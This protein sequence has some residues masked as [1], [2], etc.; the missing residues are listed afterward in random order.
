MNVV[1]SSARRQTHEA[2]A[3]P[4]AHAASPSE[5]VVAG[6]RRAELLNEMGRRGEALAACGRLLEEFG[7]MPGADVV[8]P[9]CQALRLIAHM[10][11]QMHRSADALTTLD[12]LLAAHGHRSE[13][14]IRL[15]IAD[16]LFQRTWLLD[17]PEARC[18][19]CDAM[20]ELLDTK[21]DAALDAQRVEARLRKAEVEHHRGLPQQALA[22]LEAAVERFD[23]STDP[24][25][26]LRVARAR[27]ASVLNLRELAQHTQAQVLCLQVAD[28]IEASLSDAAAELRVEGVRALALFFDG[29]GFEEQAR[30]AELVGWLLE[31]YGR[32]ASSQVRRMAAV[33]AYDWA[34]GLRDRGDGEAALAACDRMLAAFA[35]DTD[36][37]V[38]RT[39]TS[40]L[41]NKGHVLLELLGRAEEALAVY[42]QLVAALRDASAPEHQVTLGKA[43][44]GRAACMRRLRRAGPADAGEL[45]GELRDAVREKIRQGRTLG[46]AG[47]PLEAVALFDEVLAAHAASPHP[48]LRRQCARALVHKAFCLVALGR[49]ADVVEAADAMDASYGADASTAMQE[50][51]ALCLQYKS[52]ALDRL[53]QRDEEVRVHDQIVARWGNSELPE[54]RARVAGALFR[55]GAALRQ[56]GRLGDAVACYDEVVAR[57]AVARES[58][59]QLWAA[60]S[61]VNKAKV[62]EKLGDATGQAKAYRVLIARF[63]ESGDAALRE[64]VANA[65][66][67]LAEAEGRQ[68]RVEQ[69]RAALEQALGRFGTALSAEQRT[70]MSRELQALKAKAL[71]RMAKQ[72]LARVMRRKA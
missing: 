42:G 62:L 1:E 70:R 65:C 39:V 58:A 51:V 9:C 50:Q 37:A 54:L 34:V 64:R 56:A 35:D 49:F 47:Q 53:G 67:W 12:R 60:R 66:E 20:S 4:D 21:A 19:A 8:A 26:V 59:L 72:A 17:D 71:G 69:Q 24:D 22:T 14:E 3:L 46:D 16:A 23:A 10:L 27:L 43:S 15:Q 6:F 2:Q 40:A 32:D 28:Q 61:M 52:T 48:E 68:G 31:R 38:Q 13:P 5:R 33:R 41:L 63:G 36:V 30:R 25:V 57:T 55:K 18:E 29:L 7:A 44:S 11:R 45:P